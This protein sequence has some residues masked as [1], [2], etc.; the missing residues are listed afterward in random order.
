VIIIKDTL[1][2]LY[3]QIEMDFISSS[4]QRKSTTARRPEWSIHKDAHPYGA[5]IDPL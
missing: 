1:A 2:P 4:S 3:P 5:N